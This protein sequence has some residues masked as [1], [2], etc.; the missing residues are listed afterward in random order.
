MKSLQDL[1]LEL[2]NKESVSPSHLFHSK[3][4]FELTPKET[5][6]ILSVLRQPTPVPP[7]RMD[8]HRNQSEPESSMISSES[9][10]FVSKYQGEDSSGSKSWDEKEYAVKFFKDRGKKMDTNCWKGE[11]YES[12]CL[13][14]RETRSG[15]CHFE[16]R[17]EEK[18][19]KSWV[20]LKGN[21]GPKSSSSSDYN[22]QSRERCRSKSWGRDVQALTPSPEN[23]FLEA[24]T[25]SGEKHCDI[26]SCKTLVD[27]CES[28]RTRVCS[29]ISQESCDRRIVGA[30]SEK[31]NCDSK[32][33][34]GQNVQSLSSN[35]SRCIEAKKITHK[36]SF[37]TANSEPTKPL[38]C[39][40]QKQISQTLG[41][42]PFSAVLSCIKYEYN[43]VVNMEEN[44]CQDT[45]KAIPS[46]EAKEVVKRALIFEEPAG[47]STENGVSN[48]N[49]IREKFPP[50]VLQHS[51]TV[52][53]GKESGR[54]TWSAREGFFKSTSLLKHVMTRVHQQT[55]DNSQG[56][57]CVDDGM[58]WKEL[59]GKVQENVTN[60]SQD[61]EVEEN[62]ELC[63]LSFT[64]DEVE[65]IFSGKGVPIPSASEKAQFRRSL[66]SATNMVF[67]SKTGLPLTSSPAP[68]RKGKSFDYDSSL[69]NI[70]AIK[71]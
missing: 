15:E 69:N 25:R 50:E 32:N 19:A 13:K 41:K 44:H 11:N 14:D 36:T 4:N 47:T 48:G 53:T 42:S 29:D 64:D 58:D 30:C 28:Y 6:E 68:L 27:S 1:K 52:E 62:K 70:A 39:L 43:Q 60:G 65:K 51:V 7:L 57:N 8:R 21:T 59:G 23:L 66:D 20:E 24:I 55:Q 38:T 16:N 3:F 34:S 12:P 26:S 2:K 17:G 5:L 67:H 33:L 45:R 56:N 61:M 40:P 22:G 54:C 18:A 35:Q 46:I 9:K 63:K 49:H 71:R 37:F 31:L 10:L